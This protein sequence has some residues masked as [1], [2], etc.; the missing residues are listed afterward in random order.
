MRVESAWVRKRPTDYLRERM[1]L[2]TQPIE[3]SRGEGESL[4]S[5]LTLFEG[6]EDI[7]AFAS[8]YPHWDADDPT[9]VYAFF[10]SGWRGKIAH[11]NARKV[12]RL[13]ADFGARRSEK[14]VVPAR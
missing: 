10:P 5:E 11:E 12:L 9:Y 1:I 6:I 13:P 4:L 2:T 14:V 7:L 8:D 3:A